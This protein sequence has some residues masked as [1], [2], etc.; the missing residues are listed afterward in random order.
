MDGAFFGSP[1]P[2]QISPIDSRLHGLA[3]NGNALVLDSALDCW[4]E[5][6]EGGGSGNPD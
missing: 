4:V 3:E 2:D 5:A 1:S 6:A